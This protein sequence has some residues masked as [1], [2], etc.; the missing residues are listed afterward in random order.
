MHETREKLVKGYIDNSK[1]SETSNYYSG[2]CFHELFGICDSRIIYNIGNE[3]VSL[4]LDIEKNNKIKREDVCTV[5]KREDIIDCGWEFT[6]EKRKGANIIEIE[7]QMFFDEK[8]NGVGLVIGVMSLMHGFSYIV[9]INPE[10][11]R[12][13]NKPSLE[14]KSLFLLSAS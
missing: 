14:T 7:L 12:A 4:S 6:L 2:W 13:M 5:Y 8:W 3:N 11:Y 10:I 9:G 1:I